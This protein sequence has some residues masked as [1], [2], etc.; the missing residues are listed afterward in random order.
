M[1]GPLPIVR[2]CRSVSFAHSLTIGSLHLYLLR[3][4]VGGGM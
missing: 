4:V 3:L 1:T 2:S